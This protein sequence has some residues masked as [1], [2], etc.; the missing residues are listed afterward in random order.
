MVV[1]FSGLGS[2]SR[3]GI[4]DCKISMSYQELKEKTDEANQTRKEKDKLY[5]S[6]TKSGFCKNEGCENKRK[7][8]NAYCG[9]C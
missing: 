3:R 2:G 5:I 8:G 6:R 7:H 4:I 1:S 9:V